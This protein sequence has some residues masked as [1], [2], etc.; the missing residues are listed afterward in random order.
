MVER[1]LLQIDLSLCIVA[2]AHTFTYKTK[3]NLKPLSCLN[4]FAY[5]D[6]LLWYIYYHF[7]ILQFT[8][9]SILWRLSSSGPTL[10]PWVE[11][12]VGFRMIYMGKAKVKFASHEELSL[13]DGSQVRGV[14]ARC[15]AWA[16][17]KHFFP[18][19]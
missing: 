6:R 18:C 13:Q 7:N 14:F 4:L 10:P 11:K 17:C 9:I 2:H 1:E 3:C 8:N 15:K 12:D 5:V 19:S 16:L